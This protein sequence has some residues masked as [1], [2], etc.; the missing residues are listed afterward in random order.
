MAGKPKAS[1]QTKR[2]WRQRFFILLFRIGLLFLAFV[3]TGAI[4]LYPHLME[5]KKQTI[6]MADQHR[7]YYAAHAGW[8]YPGAIWSG[9]VPLYTETARLIEHAKIREYTEQC[10]AK[11]PG[12]FCPTDGSII[13]RG[14]VFP[15]GVQPPGNKGWTRPLALEPIQIGMLI[16]KEG[17]LREHLPIDEVPQVLIDALLASEDADFYSHQGINFIALIRAFW[18]N[19]QTGSYSQGASTINMQVIR[20]LSQYKEKTL[21]RKLDEIAA[22]YFLDQYLSKNEILQLYVNI[23]YLG[24][25]RSYPICG[26]S[27]AAKHY[28]NKSIQEITL[29]E[30][31]TLVGIL[32][33]PGLYRPDKYPEK[34][35]KR[36]NQVLRQM[37]IQ[38]NY[39][40]GEAFQK[41]IVVS[42]LTLPEPKY[43]DFLSY[44]YQWL[45]E[46]YDDKTLYGSGIN[47]FT[48]LDVVLQERSKKMLPFWL[49]KLQEKTGYKYQSPVET[50]GA[51]IDTKKG[52]LLALYGGNMQLHTDF[53]RATQAKRQA[54]SSFKPLVYALA[55][56]RTNRAGKPQWTSF[57]TVR[58]Y[59][60]NFSGTDGWRPRNT[61]GYYSKKSSLAA[62]LARSQNIATADLLQRLGGPEPLI[63][64]AAEFGFDTSAFPREMG[65]ALGQAEVTPLELTRFVASI[66]NGGR[67]SRGLPVISG[68]D[69]LGRERI[70]QSPIGYQILNEQSAALIRELM[71]LVVTS[72]TGYSSRGVG[73]FPGY[74]GSAI[75]KTGTTDKSKDL[76]FIGATPKYSAS[77]WIG[78][79]KPENLYVSA[80]DFAAPLWGWWM[81]SIH[82]D[83]EEASDFEGMDLDSMPI[84]RET[85]LN[86]NRSCPLIQAPVLK[87]QKPA[88]YC[89][90]EHPKIEKKYYGLWFRPKN[91]TKPK[92][93]TKI[94]TPQKPATKSIEELRKDLLEQREKEEELESVVPPVPF[95]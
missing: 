73:A 93:R 64:F 48:S 51:I 90:H 55:F 7:K 78:M 44:V 31:A 91:Y 82:K 8:S 6:A 84:C 27:M 72:G 75:G 56:S 45:E 30:A 18:F 15:E 83:I 76:W 60:H 21:T 63:Q 89:P 53:N 58:N 57:D 25:Y 4:A 71:R 54:G 22:A 52:T 49:N 28:Y 66:G 65:L 38:K 34:A 69:L 80:S 43:P 19:M 74:K 85:G 1:P 9:S 17:E 23:P 14:G 94:T 46:N 29:D 62:G 68:K 16:G 26:F 81:H 88:G 92:K 5:I 32:P 87:G 2:S 61:S 41:P 42:S 37:A 3:I 39:R 24:Q 70:M 77:L 95:E 86:P 20:N 12:S 36:R 10:P 67:I 79:D 11:S 50:A 35:K 59:K 47:I 40:I 13:P 33:A